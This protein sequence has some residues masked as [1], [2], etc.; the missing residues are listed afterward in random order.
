MKILSF[1]FPLVLLACGCAHTIRVQDEAGKPIAHASVA[2]VR[3]SLAP[4]PVGETDTKGR[5][6]F[7]STPGVELLKVSRD[8]FRS[9]QFAGSGSVPKKI[10]LQKE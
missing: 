6:S 2:V 4:D 1:L 8:G 3:Y 5:F 10:I 7:P 9:Y